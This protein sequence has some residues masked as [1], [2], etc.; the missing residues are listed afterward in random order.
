MEDENE[1]LDESLNEE[2]QVDFQDI[3]TYHPLPVLFITE[4]EKMRLLRDPAYYPLLRVLRKGPYTVKE[5]T[6]RYNTLV[7]ELK[8]TVGD[9]ERYKLKKEKTIYQ[10]LRILQDAGLIIESGQ[11]VVFGKT[12]TEKLYSRIAIAFVYS[13][14]EESYYL[15]GGGKKLAEKVGMFFSLATDKKIKDMEKFLQLFQKIRKM[16]EEMTKG[17]FFPE[18]EKT[19][20]ATKILAEASFEEIARILDYSSALI[21]FYKMDKLKRELEECLE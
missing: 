1:V 6:D 5:I 16:Q 11:R 13:P 2:E 18:T 19:T 14:T 8:K 12:A 4:Q 9:E 17:V 3:I 20:E 7:E 21:L 15:E 10:Y